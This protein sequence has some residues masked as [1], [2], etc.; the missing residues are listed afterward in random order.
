LNARYQYAHCRTDILSL[1]VDERALLIGPSFFLALVE[2]IL[3]PE[4]PAGKDVALE[5]PSL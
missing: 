2:R 5:L 1:A 3:G 4:A